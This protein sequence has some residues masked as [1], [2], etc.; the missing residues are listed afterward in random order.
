MKDHLQQFTAA[1]LGIALMWWLAWPGFFTFDTATQLAQARGIIPLDDANPPIMAL[2]WRGLAAVWA[3]PGAMFALIT[4]GYWYA[5]AAL[6]WK[7]FDRTAWRWSVFA[8][9]ALWPPA[10][11]TMCHVWKDCAMTAALVAACV[12]IVNWRQGGCRAWIA[13]AL[14]WLAVSC[15]LRYNAILAAAPLTLW[16]CWPRDAQ[17]ASRAWV[18]TGAVAVLLSIALLVFPSLFARSVGA[19]P[20]HAWTTVALWDLAGVS[21]RE[22]TMLIPER[23]FNRPTTV[24]DLALDYTPVTNVDTFIQNRIKLSYYQ[25]YSKADLDAL[26]QAWTGAILHHTRAYLAH[27][28]AFSRW[29]FLGYAQDT[30]HGLAFSPNR[31]DQNFIK[32]G[33]PPVNEH[34]PWLRA[35]EWLRTT[36]LFAGICYIVIA[37]FAAAIAWRR[38][39]LRDPLPVL[40]LTTSALGNALPLA[41]ISGSCDFRY[42]IWTVITALLALPLA[43]LPASIEARRA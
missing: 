41:I 31:Y 25:D 26:W 5:L 7:L 1:A 23:L 27:R 6:I 24:A 2:A 28:L 37:L 14:F 40:A 9:V 21:I 30:P 3:Y 12:C 29:Q 34:A 19:T 8:L 10:F 13:G 32:L 38:R 11:V 17:P 18:K 43:F 36:P 4:V 16:L 33:L 20:R 15:C 42:M 35:M 22:N 39:A